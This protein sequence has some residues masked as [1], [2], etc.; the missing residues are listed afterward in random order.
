MTE[1]PHVR[2]QEMPEAREGVRDKM[3]MLTRM[4][5]RIKK[6]V[7]STLGLKESDAVS[8]ETSSRESR[9][10]HGD[11]RTRF[12][13]TGTS[14]EYSFEFFDM[15]FATVP[16]FTGFLT[17]KEDDEPPP[18]ALAA[19][20][21]AFLKQVPGEDDEAHFRDYTPTQYSW[22]EAR[23]VVVNDLF[24]REMVQHFWCPNHFFS[25]TS[26]P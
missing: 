4:L 14:G 26:T 2:R 10:H 11:F 13:P 3:P 16:I 7:Q 23:A 5:N 22:A 17:V 18:E 25:F 20:L 24:E 9:R 19:H 1:K 12:I 15:E 21:L 6:Y 8:P